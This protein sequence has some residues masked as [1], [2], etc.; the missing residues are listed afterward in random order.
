MSK[1]WGMSKVFEDLI[2]YGTTEIFEF[3][4]GGVLLVARYNKSM[5][6]QHRWLHRLFGTIVT[7][8]FQAVIG[9]EFRGIPQNPYVRSHIACWF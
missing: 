4:N 9:T 7:P 2:V 8:N 1:G 3:N 5:R 6:A